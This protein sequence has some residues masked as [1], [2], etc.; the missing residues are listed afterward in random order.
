MSMC[1]GSIPAF[2]LEEGLA[3][4]RDSQGGNYLITLASWQH[5]SCFHSPI[6]VLERSDLV[7]S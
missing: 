3:R 5:L 2:F 1:A 4:F 7:A 6:G